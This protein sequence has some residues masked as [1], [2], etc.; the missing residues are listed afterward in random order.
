MPSITERLS[1][2]ELRELLQTAMDYPNCRAP[3]HR[4]A[5]EPEGGGGYIDN[6]TGLRYARGKLIKGHRRPRR[7]RMDADLL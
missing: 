2:L 4:L 6:I 1:R 7:K 5:W 3:S